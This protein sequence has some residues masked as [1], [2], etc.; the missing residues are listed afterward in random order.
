[1][2]L[3]SIISEVEDRGKTL[4]MFNPRSSEVV[5]GLRELFGA[6]QVRVETASTAAGPKSFATLSE[7]GTLLTAIDLAGVEP[8]DLDTVLSP[9]FRFLDH[10]TF[11]SFDVREMIATSRE[12]E[13]RAWR[14]GVGQ[15]HAG[16][17]YLSSFSDQSNVYRDLTRKDLDIFVYAVEA[18]SLSDVDDLTL[19]L[20]ENPEIDSTWFVVYDGGENPADKCALLAEE[21]DDGGFYGFWTYDGDLVDEVLDYLGRTYLVLA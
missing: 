11:S 9:A 13:D 1:M 12:I 10:S 16:F 14:A 17:R 19:H 8:S 18:T 2:S 15:L 4:T 5:D 20:T 7:G 3:H 6:T 21:R